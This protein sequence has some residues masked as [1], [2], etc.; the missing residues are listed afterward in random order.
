MLAY[1][2][3]HR[4]NRTERA[5]SALASEGAKT[6]AHQTRAHRAL[7]WRPA[8]GRYAHR[9][10]GRARDEPADSAVCAAQPLDPVDAADELLDRFDDCWIGCGRRERRARLRQLHRLAGR[11]EQSVM[12]DAL[13]A[14][15]QHMQ[16]E[17]L[18]EGLRRHMERA[19]AIT[20]GPIARTRKRTVS[21][22]M[23][24]MRSL[25][26]ATRCV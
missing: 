8:H 15:G 1:E 14:L 6:K 3:L 18:D 2:R 4:V 23:P 22:S 21:A 26:I 9:R 25:E 16:E 12:A 7:S 11:A 13:E 24:R 5:N 10:D 20:V 19:L 17:P